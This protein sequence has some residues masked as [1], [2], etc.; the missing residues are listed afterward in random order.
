[1]LKQLTLA[2]LF[3]AASAGA[4]CAQ[5]DLSSLP[6]R[7]AHEGLLVAADPYQ[8]AERYKARFGKKNPSDA[9]ILAI[10]VFLRNDNDRPIRLDLQSIRLLLAPSGFQRQQLGPLAV[11][12]VVDR[13]LNK[14]GPNPTVSRRPIPLPGR[15]PKTGRGKEW[16]QLEAALRGAAF[17]MDVLPPRSSVHGFLF[18]DV[19]HRYDWLPYARLYVPDVTF[20]DNKQALLFFEVNLAAAVSP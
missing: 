10:E 3:W 20:L 13:I 7:D 16:N 8:S 15:G 19:N 17:D 9:G 12:D 1:M 2:L 4:A 6:A 5:V 14:G 18:F 11:E